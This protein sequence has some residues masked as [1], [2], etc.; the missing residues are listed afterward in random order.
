MFLFD[1]RHAPL[2]GAFACLA[3]LA[4]L[5]ATQ[6]EADALVGLVSATTVAVLLLLQTWIVSEVRH[7][8]SRPLDE[9]EFSAVRQWIAALV[10]AERVPPFHLRVRDG[11]NANAVTSGGVRRHFVVVGRGLLDQLSTDEVKAVL[12]HEIGRLLNR[13]MT[14]RLVP[15]LC[16]NYAFHALYVTALVAVLGLNAVT[17]FF[18][19]VGIAIFWGIVPGFFQRR[20][21]FDADR[22]A[23]E[24]IG[25]AE[26][27]I[28]ALAK[29]SEVAG[30]NLDGRAMTHPPMRARLEALK[31]LAQAPR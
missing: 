21:V 18:G 15:M 20:W 5:A 3:I 30:I 26:V 10:E 12:A 8:R 25:D 16:L 9:A 22:R 23:V 11:R 17:A 1:L 31:Q 27:C 13:D 28:Q 2:V 7:R 6:P 24:L 4:L 19:G 14:R 29:F